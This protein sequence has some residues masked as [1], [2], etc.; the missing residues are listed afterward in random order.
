MMQTLARRALQRASSSSCSCSP[1]SCRPSSSA[2]F[3]STAS[4]AIDPSRLE[5]TRAAASAP[6]VPKEQLLFGKTFTDHMLEIDWTKDGGWAAPKISPMG[7]LDLH[8]AASSLHYGLQCFEGMKAYVDADEKVRLFRPE[9]NMLRMNS[10]MDRL[11]LPQFNGAELLEC[12]KELV[13]LDSDWIPRGEG[14]SLYLRPT[15]IST[16]PTLGVGRP[17]Q[18]RIF[19]ILSPVGPYYPEGFKPVNLFASRENVRAWPGGT[20]DTKIGGCVACSAACSSRPALR[21]A[22]P[23]AVPHR[24]RSAPHSRSR[25]RP[26]FLPSFLPS[27][28]PFRA[29]SSQRARRN[30]A[31]TISPQTAAANKGYTQVLWLFGEDA[32]VTEVGTMNVFCI[33]LHFTRILLTV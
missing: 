19:V 13:K 28:L 17:T 18:A 10:S 22:P 20:G 16:Q 7:A 15:G 21:R 5:I 12:I 1:S 23:H 30:Y 24:L 3:S 6:R 29:P 2:L 32:E 9:M 27:F 26:Y 33:P 4:S 31:S 25:S 8:P 11:C 14:Y